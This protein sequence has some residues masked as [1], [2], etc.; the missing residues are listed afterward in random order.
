M[1]P[2][3]PLI[4]SPRSG[5]AMKYSVKRFKSLK[6]AIKELEPFIRNDQ[7]L[8]TGRPSKQFGDMR[9]REVL[10]N[11]LL[12]VVINSA[13]GAEERVTFSSDPNDGDGIIHDDASG[14][15]WPTEHVLVPRIGDAAAGNIENL[16]LEKIEQKQS[17]GGAAYA[18]GRMPIVF[19]DSGGGPWYP[20]EVA[21]QL[22]EQLDF[23]AV[24]VVG[25]QEVVAGEYVY[26]VTREDDFGSGTTP[27]WRV[28]ISP[29]FENW[30][31]EPIGGAT[32]AAS[33]RRM[34]ARPS[35]GDK[36]A[37][38]LRP[39]SKR[40]RTA[41]AGTDAPKAQRSGHREPGVYIL[42]RRATALRSMWAQRVISRSDCGAMHERAASSATPASRGMRWMHS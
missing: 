39:P 11:W 14:Y 23:D 9:S 8:T 40:E 24:W 35:S 21:K 17:K 19:L 34:T 22:P 4:P 32:Q 2:P 36:L 27:K 18:S 25:L 10:A 28:R 1:A 29:D 42:R 31:V 3:C 7:N 12:C 5:E 37:R 13:E 38:F 33:K 30:A 26:G 6:L 16:I 41:L 15:A 20:N